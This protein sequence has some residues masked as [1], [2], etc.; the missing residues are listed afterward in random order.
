MRFDPQIEVVCDECG[1][2]DYWC[3]DYV[4]HSMSGKS[5]QYDTSDAAFADWCGGEGWTQDGE[6]T[7]CPDCTSGDT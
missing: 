7:F 1:S 3:P 5:G 2:H 6:K 4:Y